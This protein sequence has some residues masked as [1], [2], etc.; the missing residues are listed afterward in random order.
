MDCGGRGDCGDL[1]H[2]LSPPDGIRCVCVFVIP[3]SCS[4]AKEV[5][6]LHPFINL[7]P[8]PRV[9]GSPTAA[10][11]GARRPGSYGC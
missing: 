6:R 9:A 7:S 8:A 2:R 3:P 10:P 5:T 11:N 4:R 1:F